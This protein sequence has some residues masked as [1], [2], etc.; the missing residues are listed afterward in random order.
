MTR[1][2]GLGLLCLFGLACA[3]APPAKGDP[4]TR[5]LE[6]KLDSMTLEGVLAWDPAVTGQ[7]PAVLIAHEGAGNGPAAKSRAMQFA[8]LGY[9]AFA[10][11]LYGKGTSPKDRADVGK[12]LSDR[13]AVAKRLEAALELLAKQPQAAPHKI[14]G[15]GYGLGATA[16]LDLARA[17]ADLEGMAC[18]HGDLT[19]AKPARTKVTCRI[20]ALMGSDDPRASIDTYKGFEGEMKAGAADWDAIRFGGVVGDFTNPSAGND[21]KSG[22]AYDS[23]AD[24]RAHAAVRQFLGELFPPAVAA[25]SFATAPKDAPKAMLKPIAPAAPKGVPEKA[26]KVLKYVDEHDRAMDG[27]EGGRNFGNFEGRLPSGD[28][29]GRRIR[30]REWDVNPLRPGVNRGAERLITGSDGSAHYTDD[31]YSTFKKIR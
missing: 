16:M 18:L 20:L 11:D 26:M 17:D 30:Y 19:M 23:D 3:Q 15:V 1:A 29:N 25:R 12:R 9:I 24:A 21:A 5:T 2:L 22:F 28:R 31:H 10:A 4:A 6:Y 8:K 14:A 27:Y 7:R 13:V